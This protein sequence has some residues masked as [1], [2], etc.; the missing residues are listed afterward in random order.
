M[1]CSTLSASVHI[2]PTARARSSCHVAQHVNLE[3]MWPS[4]HEGLVMEKMSRRPS[5]RYGHDVVSS[6]QVAE[7]WTLTANVLTGDMHQHDQGKLS[8]P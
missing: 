5:W 7:G 3:S 2:E 1:L 8:L 4:L 6:R